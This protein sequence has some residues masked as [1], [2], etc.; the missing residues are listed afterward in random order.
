ML[1]LLKAFTIHEDQCWK[2][3]L[4][5]VVIIVGHYL[6]NFQETYDFDQVPTYKVEMYQLSNNE[7]VDKE[8][9]SIKAK[10][11]RCFFLVLNYVTKYLHTILVSCYKRH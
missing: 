2:S 5:F 3:L 6:Q 7:S 8:T 1:K 4:D 10:I 9:H 11:I